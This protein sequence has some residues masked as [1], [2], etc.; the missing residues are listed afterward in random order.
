[1][2]NSYREIVN[3]LNSKNARS[4]HYNIFL[5]DPDSE[6]E[7]Y[8]NKK[9]QQI[10]NILKNKYQVILRLFGERNFQKV[11]YEYFQYNPV[12]SS[13]LDHYGKSFSDFLG[14][15]D[16]L[17]EFRYLK[18]IAKLDWFWFGPVEDGDSIT[19]PK[20]TLKS[21]SILYK[22]QDLVDIS[23]DESIIETLQIKKVGKEIQ[24]VPL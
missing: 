19:L 3:L 11:A 10:Y 16:Q 7:M 9:F 1:M 21:W 23:I 18:W 13:K 22:D 15:V 14:S 24:I 6:Q 4:K 20:G 2:D 8:N 17:R 5:H 12:Q